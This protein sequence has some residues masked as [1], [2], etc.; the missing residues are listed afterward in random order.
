MSEEEAFQGVTIKYKPNAETFS[1]NK[2]TLLLKFI[3]NYTKQHF[4]SSRISRYPDVNR[5]P[6]GYKYGLGQ[7]FRNV[8]DLK[9]DCHILKHHEDRKKM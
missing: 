4:V 6:V 2:F 3:L 5:Y 9:R 7:Q 1:S 8:P